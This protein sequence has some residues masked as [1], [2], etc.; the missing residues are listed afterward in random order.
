MSVERKTPRTD[1]QRLKHV[2]Y[3]GSVADEDGP[4]VSY[5]FAR[6]LEIETQ[7]LAEALDRYASLSDCDLADAAFEA[8]AR[9]RANQ[10]KEAQ[11]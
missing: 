8:L 11:P 5:D 3:V 2:R 4:F 7:K 10:P 6:A 1:A 9:H